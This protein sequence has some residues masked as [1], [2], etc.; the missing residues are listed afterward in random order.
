M[1]AQAPADRQRGRKARVLAG[2][3]GRGLQPQLG[4]S[5]PG[6]AALGRHPTLSGP[7]VP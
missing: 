1:S 6:P 2:G 5:L 7:S 3:W 4:L